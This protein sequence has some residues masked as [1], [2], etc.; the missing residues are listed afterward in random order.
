MVEIYIMGTVADL[1]LM[2]INIQ[3]TIK[4]SLLMFGF[5]EFVVFNRV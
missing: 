2:Y 3:Q 1:L 4:A 5:N